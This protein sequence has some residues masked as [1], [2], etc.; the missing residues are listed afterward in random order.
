MYQCLSVHFKNMPL[1]HCASVTSKNGNKWIIDCF[2]RYPEASTVEDTQSSTV[3][4]V[5]IHFISRHGMMEVFYSDRRANFISKAMMEVYE[6]SGNKKQQ[7]TSLADFGIPKVR[8]YLRWY[9]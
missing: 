6:K 1:L 5:L 9:G 3:A 8:G 7:T 2:T 4:S